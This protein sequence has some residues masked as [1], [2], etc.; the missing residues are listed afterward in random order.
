MNTGFITNTGLIMNIIEDKIVYNDGMHNNL[1]NKLH[2]YQL[3][4][5]RIRIITKAKAPIK[6]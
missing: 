3:R 2:Q 6:V 1:R 5:K 4:A